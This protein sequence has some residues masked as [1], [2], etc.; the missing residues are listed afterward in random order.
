MNTCQSLDLSGYARAPTSAWNIVIPAKATRKR[1]SRGRRVLR[2]IPWTSASAEE[3]DNTLRVLGSLRIRFYPIDISISLFAAAA[4][5]SRR[6]TQFW[7][8]SVPSA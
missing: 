8:A 6:S 2:L 5:H 1:E 7:A 4:D 3:T